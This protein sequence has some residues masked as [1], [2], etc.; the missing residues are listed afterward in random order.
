MS[1]ISI[2]NPIESL[3][4]VLNNISPRA[5]SML[6]S[7]TRTELI[8]YGG[9]AFYTV[10]NLVQYIKNKPEKYNK[11][12]RVPFSLPLFGHS[13]Y[14]FWDSHRFIDW[15]I[16]KYGEVYELSIMGKIVT[17]ASGNSGQEAL[18]AESSFLSLEEGIIKDI[19]YLQ[20]AID[21][22]TFEIGFHVNPIVAKAIVASNKVPRHT[23]RILKGMSDGFKNHFPAQDTFVIDNPNYVFQRIIAHMSVPTLI[24]EEVGTNQI[25]IESFA[26][27]TADITGN[28]PIFMAV[29]EFLHRFI[30][31]YLQTITKHRLI[32]SQEITPVVEA[33]I[34]AKLDSEAK[35]EKY[36]ARDDFLQGLL[37]FVK[38]D[39]THYTPDEVAQATLLIAFASVH[40]T[41]VNLAYCLN[42]ITSRPDIKQKLLEEIESVVGKDID[43]ELTFEH[44]EKMYY[45]DK[46]LR[47][48]IRQG[49]DVL[50]AGR[51][52]LKPF[53]FSNGYQV[54]VG[55]VV[56]ATNRQI[57]M[58]IST[59]RV[60]IQDMDPLESGSRPST[61]ASR[62]YV[63]F[64][65][66]KHLCPGRFFAVLEIKLTIVQIMRQYD[67]TYTTKKPTHPIKL[68]G[69]FMAIN[70][71]SPIRFTK[72]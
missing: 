61:S 66:G 62:D 70:A 16:A 56:E 65:L 51:K 42:W 3:L 60:D 57:N 11:P 38:P 35:G 24:G 59:N 36:E 10:Y 1:D 15:C 46:V 12:P 47:E 19:L 6:Q 31:P 34:Q 52:C 71:N 68:I 33:R 14:L 8:L 64:G 17:V 69:G 7:A 27:F 58:G 55:H 9:T 67:I 29:P 45:L 72:R 20:Y 37:E 25:V 26:A 53:T 41:T 5:V 28:I 39:G 13:L 63:T 21:T 49:T 30:L 2:S 50:A 48:S 18:K 23:Q 44:L 43:T 22:T 32:M 40:T 4:G 54:P